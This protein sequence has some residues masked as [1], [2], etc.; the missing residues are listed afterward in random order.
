MAPHYS[1]IVAK[2]IDA[3]TP[4]VGAGSSAPHSGDIGYIG[5][6]RFQQPKNFDSLLNVGCIGQERFK[7]PEKVESLPEEPNQYYQV[8]LV[9]AP[10]V[11]R[12]I[13]P[14]GQPIQPYQSWCSENMY[15][16]RLYDNIY[17]YL[18]SVPLRQHT[19]DPIGWPGSYHA[20]SLMTSGQDGDTLSHCEYLEV[21][22]A[23]STI[24]ADYF[25]GHNFA[26]GQILNCRWQIQSRLSDVKGFFNRG[27]HTVKDL[28]GAP[29]VPCM[30]KVLPSEGM[31]SG[32][33][34]REIDIMYLLQ[35]H[36]NIVTL[37]DAMLPEHPR[38][39]PWMVMDMCNGGTLQQC[40]NK[41]VH[42]PLPELF[43]WYVFQ[44]LAE[45]IRHCQFGPVG[46]SL[47]DWEIVFH[48]DIIPN[49]ILLE[50][51]PIG[52][53]LWPMVKLA[54]FGCAVTEWEMEN[55]GLTVDDL[56]EEDP[57]AVP[58]EGP[59][60]SQAADI[61]QI[62]R[63]IETMILSKEPCVGRD[64]P[65]TRYSDDLRS[66]VQRC[67]STKPQDRPNVER[68]L[69]SIRSR[70]AQLYVAREIGYEEL[71]Y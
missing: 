52:Q 8:D 13:T 54:D 4:P 57:A 2:M 68:L 19:E 23:L 28:V 36:P 6:E 1:H 34:S 48:R 49:N 47:D 21:K 3:L 60:P 20:F 56:P 26:A 62:G 37:Q 24:Y 11:G 10:L 12:Y 65:D 14:A 55:C 29:D 69:D 39:A 43:V 63:V 18:C 5:Q 71:L 42:K 46:G 58:P 27:I 51:P 15:N 32:Y 44:S 31:Y 59:V 40:I 67:M 45:A 22:H 61:Y 35:G 66:S 50:R 33:A 70:M 53:D 7:Q 64:K 38:L 9:G 17:T 16:P 30:V 25:I 41:N